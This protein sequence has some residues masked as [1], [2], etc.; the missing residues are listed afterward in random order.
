MAAD[1]PE[2]TG[3][4]PLTIEQPRSVAWPLLMLAGLI[5]LKR[6]SNEVRMVGARLLVQAP[7]VMVLAITS[8]VLAAGQWAVANYLVCALPL[9][10]FALHRPAK[11]A[12]PCGPQGVASSHVEEPPRSGNTHQ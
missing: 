8:A 3:F 1:A 4:S 2:P 7:W 5:I 12:P 11:W 10:A 6:R 9:M